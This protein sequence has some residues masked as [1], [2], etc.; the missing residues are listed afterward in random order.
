[1]SRLR[2]EAQQRQKGWARLDWLWQDWR[3]GA[4]LCSSRSSIPPHPKSATN[5][6]LPP[7]PCSPHKSIRNLH[8]K[9]LLLTWWN[10]SWHWKSP[11]QLHQKLQKRLSLPTWCPF[12]Y[13]WG[14]LR[15]CTSAGLR[16]AK[17]GHQPHMPQSMHMC[18]E[19][20][21]GWGWHVPPAARDSSTQT[22]SGITG[23]IMW[24][25]KFN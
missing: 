17:R 3:Q 5:P 11:L 25:N 18:T 21:C 2:E 23:G 1:M 22:P 7:S 4:M 24:L 6:Q 10:Q 19:C 12:T 16:A 14:P 8:L 15:G 20:T 9:L 13:S